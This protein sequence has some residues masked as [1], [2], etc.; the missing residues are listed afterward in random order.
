MRSEGVTQR[1]S[2]IRAQAIIALCYGSLLS[3][4]AWSQTCDPPL[5]DSI[6]A[7]EKLVNLLPSG[8]ME[9]ESE[10]RQATERV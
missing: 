8:R 6:L 10:F 3:P 9:S 7:T 4:F 1:V 5:T 2:A